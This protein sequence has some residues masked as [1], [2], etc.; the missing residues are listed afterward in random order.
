MTV[1]TPAEFYKQEQCWDWTQAV[2]YCNESRKKVHNLFS[3]KDRGDVAAFSD[4]L[5]KA[6]LGAGGG[7]QSLQVCPLP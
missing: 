4:V 3:L 2:N 7:E 1:N 6:V 5:G